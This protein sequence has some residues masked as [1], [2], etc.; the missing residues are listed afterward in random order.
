MAAHAIGI[1]FQ[2]VIVGLAV[3]MRPAHPLLVLLAPHQDALLLDEVTPR[4]HGPTDSWSDIVVG[5]GFGFGLVFVWSSFSFSSRSGICLGLGLVSAFSGVVLVWSGVCLWFL[6]PPSSFR[7]ERKEGEKERGQVTPFL[8]FER[9][10]R[11]ERGRE[12]EEGQREGKNGEGEIYIPSRGRVVGT[13][14]P[15]P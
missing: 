8:P 7:G 2:G 15:S 1:C 4:T 11:R 9:E 14:P 13:W 6:L 12:I 5:F 3:H 10:G